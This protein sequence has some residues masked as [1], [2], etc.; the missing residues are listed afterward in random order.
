MLHSNAINEL[1][2]NLLLRLTGNQNK[3]K[4]CIKLELLHEQQWQTSKQPLGPVCAND[5]LYYMQIRAH[6][7]FA[8]CKRDCRTVS[9]SR[10]GGGGGESVPNQEA[11]KNSV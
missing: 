1:K 7:G 5:W 8:T 10:A 2:Q 11:G 4:A 3:F 6:N 9:P